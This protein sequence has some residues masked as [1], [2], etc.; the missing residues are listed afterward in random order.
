M[1]TCRLAPTRT[2]LALAALLAFSLPLPASAGECRGLKS[3]HCFCRLL[4]GEHNGNA[5]SLITPPGY[6]GKE[7][8]TYTIPNQ[9]FNQQVDAGVYRINKGC[10][11]AC[12]NAYGVDGAAP[13][14]GMKAAIAQAAKKL[15][16]VGY[17]GGWM[18]APSL[19][20]AGTNKYRANTN[21]GIGVGIGGTASVINGK[22]ICK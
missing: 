11:L 20:A 10:W 19:F 4:F 2:L 3:A 5:G 8:M 22:K 18:N 15:R 13:D 6:D 7:L 16:A 9:C 12:R 1:P 17:C 21:V 14:P